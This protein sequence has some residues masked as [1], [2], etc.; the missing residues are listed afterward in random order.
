MMWDKKDVIDLDSGNYQLLEELVPVKKEH[1][2]DDPMEVEKESRSPDDD[3]LFGE[4]EEA[5][6]DMQPTFYKVIQAETDDSG[7]SAVDKL[8]KFIRTLKCDCHLDQSIIKFEKMIQE[9]EALVEEF[10]SGKT[11]KKLATLLK[12]LALL[13]KAIQERQ[14]NH[15][16][17]HHNVLNALAVEKFRYDAINVRPG[18]GAPLATKRSDIVDP[19]DYKPSRKN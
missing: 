8:P 1:P 14:A 17:D 13:G 9:S 16:R 18:E 3:D 19:L 6:Q 10:Q 2:V 12:R 4:D 7:S 5:L 15:E 11:R